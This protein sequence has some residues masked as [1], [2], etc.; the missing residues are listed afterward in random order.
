MFPSHTSDESRRESSQQYPRSPHC[1]ARHLLHLGHLPLLF[2]QAVKVLALLRHAVHVNHP[3]F[4]LQVI[5]SRHVVFVGHGPRVV[6]HFVQPYKRVVPQHPGSYSLGDIISRTTPN[7]IPA[8]HRTTS[9]RDGICA[10][11]LVISLHLW[12]SRDSATFV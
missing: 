4:V 12:G 8:I 6:P 5:G 10:P 1:L 2:S 7:G 11:L 3:R 9:L